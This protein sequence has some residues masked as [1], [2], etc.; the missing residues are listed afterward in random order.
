MNQP[1]NKQDQF[2]RKRK[3]D[4][5]GFVQNFNNRF[6]RLLDD[7]TSRSQDPKDLI[8]PERIRSLFELIID[9]KRLKQRSVSLTTLNKESI[10]RYADS[11]DSHVIFII[12]PK[13]R[14]LKQVEAFIQSIKKREITKNYSLV[15]YPRRNVLSQFLI[16]K[17]NLHL[18]FMTRIYDFN[19][20]LIPLSLDL[21]SLENE[22][23]LREMMVS[24]EFNSFNF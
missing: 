8:F 21:L 24:K 19:L 20:D 18:D 11:S 16:R 7:I 15:I 2:K 17:Y 9:Q 10:G 5:S 4:V 14:A 13:K 1:G 23:C 6:S 12:P 3:I 22:E